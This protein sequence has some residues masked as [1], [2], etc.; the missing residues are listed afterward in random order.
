MGQSGSGRTFLFPFILL[1]FI[2]ILSPLL[3]L[4]RCSPIKTALNWHSYASR[5]SDAH[6]L[7]RQSLQ[8][9]WTSSLELSADRPQTAGLVIQSCLIII[10]RILYSATMPLGGYRVAVYSRWRHFYLGS[11]TILTE[12]F[13]KYC[14]LLTSMDSVMCIITCYDVSVVSAWRCICVV[15]AG[16]GWAT[17]TCQYHYDEPCRQRS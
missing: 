14:Y 8:C 9:S 17:A 10:I 7:G 2:F 15:V 6:W 11:A 13:K 4:D 5:Q 1:Y 12:F 16:V 3:E